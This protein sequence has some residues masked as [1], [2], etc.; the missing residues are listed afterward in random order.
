MIRL[1]VFRVVSLLP[2]LNLFPGQ[3]EKKILPNVSLLLYVYCKYFLR[4][5]ERKYFIMKLSYLQNFRPPGNSEW[6]DLTLTIT[7]RGKHMIRPLDL[8]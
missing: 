7:V 5:L 4:G 8:D 2:G 1:L 3:F 6:Y